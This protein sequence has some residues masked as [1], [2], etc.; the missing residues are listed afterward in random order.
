MSFIMHTNA[1]NN[2]TDQDFKKKKTILQTRYI[3]RSLYLRE[4]KKRKRKRER[5]KAELI[6]KKVDEIQR[7]TGNSG[8]GGDLAANIGPDFPVDLL[9]AVEASVLVGEGGADPRLRIAHLPPEVGA[10]AEMMQLRQRLAQLLHRV[11]HLVH[12]VV[13]GALLPPPAALHLRQKLRRPTHLRQAHPH[14]HLR[15]IARG[16]GGAAVRR[17]RPQADIW[18]AGVDAGG[19]HE[20]V[21]RRSGGVGG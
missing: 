8:D 17:Q 20:V 7:V 21:L 4:R 16:T 3:Y 14:R 10:A 19:A 9:E 2:I 13:E 11:S 12:A 5:E 1:S 18:V 6:V 15:Q